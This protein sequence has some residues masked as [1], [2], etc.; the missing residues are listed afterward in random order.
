MSW[1]TGSGWEWTVN[2]GIRRR[3]APLLGKNRRR[4]ELL[5]SLSAGYSALFAHQARDIVKPDD[6]DYFEQCVNLWVQ[7]SS[8]VFLRAYLEAAKDGGFLPGTREEFQALLDIFLLDKA[9]YEM[10]YE[11]NNR[12]DWLRIPF[13]GLL[14]L[15]SKG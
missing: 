8:R 12:P 4:I 9:I 15:M 7:W 14:T 10:G 3:L 13:K 11:L 1:T 2:L 5:S 6:L